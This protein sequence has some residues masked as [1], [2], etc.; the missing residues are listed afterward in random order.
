MVGILQTQVAQN[1]NQ[2]RTLE[3]EAS[4]HQA[5][6]DIILKRMDLQ[7]GAMKVQEKQGDIN[8]KR[9]KQA[10]QLD[11]AKGKSNGRGNGGVGAMALPPGDASFY[12]DAGGVDGGSAPALG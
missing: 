11:E 4:R 2:I 1:E 8:F 5:R 9:E 7:L 12:V 3:L 6:A 10:A